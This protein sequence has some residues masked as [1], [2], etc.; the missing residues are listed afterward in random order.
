MSYTSLNLEHKRELLVNFRAILLSL[1][2]LARISDT[3][4]ADWAKEFATRAYIDV[5][6]LSDEQVEQVINDIEQE[7]KLSNDLFPEFHISTA[8]RKT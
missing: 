2:I 6:A 1:Q 5:E 8:V 4:M 3:E 7:R